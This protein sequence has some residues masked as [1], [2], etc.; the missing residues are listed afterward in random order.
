MKETSVPCGTLPPT[1]AD[2]CIFP[3]RQIPHLPMVL[4]SPCIPSFPI[5]TEGESASAMLIISQRVPVSVTGSEIILMLD[6]KKLPSITCRYV[7]NPVRGFPWTELVDES[8]RMLKPKNTNNS[9]ACDTV[10]SDQKIIHAKQI[11]RFMSFST[12][13]LLTKKI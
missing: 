1:A 3:P 8:C 9:R 10:Y 12:L 6:N 5:S 4:Y 7:H 2:Q 11:H 13:L